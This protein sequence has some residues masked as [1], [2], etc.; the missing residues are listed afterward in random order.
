MPHPFS[1]ACSRRRA[2]LLGAALAALLL[3][4]GG[5]GSS[6]DPP[7]PDRGNVHYPIGLEM[8]PD[9]RFLYVVNTNF[10]ARYKPDSGGTVSVVDIRSMEIRAESTPYLPSFGGSIELNDDAS[11]AYV[12]A[13]E[14]N[15]LVVFRVSEQTAD[16]DAGASLYCLDDEGE[17]T[18]DPSNCS[19]ERVPPNGSGTPFPGD[20]FDLSVTTLRRDIPD[21]NAMEEVPVDVV[22]LSYLGSNR[23]STV[24]FP[25]RQ[26]SNAAVETAALIPGSNAITRRPET[27]SYYVAGR[28]THVVSRFSPFLNFRESGSFGEVE[29]LFKQGDIP[30][31]NFTSRNGRISIDARGIGFGPEGNR[32][33]V[34]ARQP[35]ALYIFDLVASNPKT[36]GGL[37]H[38]LAASIPLSD[39]PSGL[40]I[41]ERADGR[42]RVYVPSYDDEV[43]DVV[44]PEIERVVDRVELPASPYDMVIDTAPDRCDGSGAPCRAY[45]SLFGD[46]GAATGSCGPNADQCGAVGVVDLDPTSSRYH[47]LVQKIR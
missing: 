36:G 27:L 23:V 21:D 12:T 5:C 19:I 30:V 15:Q 45:V 44:D 41:H 26:I 9:G 25:D 43:I 42:R 29:A 3:V 37:D 16:A 20:P 46:T 35:D 1:F 4:F 14:D 38:D 47:R 33:F 34:A 24:T 2:A 39:S 13:R 17:P 18:S 31:S 8:H 10:N 40:V 28:E 11:R 32:L 6:Y 22:S 7:L